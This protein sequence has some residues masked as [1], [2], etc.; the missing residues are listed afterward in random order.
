MW[1]FGLYYCPLWLC[2]IY[3]LTVYGRIIRILRATFSNAVG[4]P[5]RDK[6]GQ[7]IRQLQLYP[8]TLVLCYACASINRIQNAVQPDRPIYGLYV[9]HVITKC[10]HGKKK[11]SARTQNLPVAHS[12][13]VPI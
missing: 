2:I 6:L 11:A 7:L 12:F 8:I 3:N 9:A 13:A 1:R 4:S 5:G 10:L